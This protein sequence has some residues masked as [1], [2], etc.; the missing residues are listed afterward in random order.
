MYAYLTLIIHKELNQSVNIAIVSHICGSFVGLPIE[1][2]NRKI[3]CKFNKKFIFN[4]LKKKINRHTN[5]RYVE[6]KSHLWC[7]VQHIYQINQ[8]DFNLYELYEQFEKRGDKQ[9]RWKQHHCM[10]IILKLCF[11]FDVHRWETDL[12]G[13]Y[14]LCWNCFYFASWIVFIFGQSDHKHAKSQKS[15]RIESLSRISAPF[16]STQFER[17]T[18]TFNQYICERAHLH[19][20][21]DSFLFHL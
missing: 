1:R 14:M 7:S 9:I 10:R 4:L 20:H 21:I 18:V 5:P 13:I 2:S 8:F 12:N 17:V 6:R 3:L 16:A 19:T 11:I 15:K